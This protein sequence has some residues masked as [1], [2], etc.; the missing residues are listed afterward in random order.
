MAAKLAKPNAALT[1][2][3]ERS[4][5]SGGP[6]LP[7]VAFAI[8]AGVAGG[9][10][11]FY[12]AQSSDGVFA[13]LAAAYSRDRHFESRFSGASYGPLT[14]TRG[15]TAGVRSPEF[16]EAQARIARQL[17]TH[18]D[19][20]EWL[21]AKARA[22]LLEGRVDTAL[23]E[24]RHA[25]ES[26]GRSPEVLGDLAIAYLQRASQERNAPDIA[27]AIDLLGQALA[28]DPSNLVYRFNRALA[29]EQL[30]APHEAA[31]DWREFLA[32]EAPGGWKGEARDHLRH[33][34]DLL[35]R[36]R[37]ASDDSGSDPRPAA[38]LSA[39]LKQTRDVTAALGRTMIADHGDKW[40]RDMAGVSSRVAELLLRGDQSNARGESDDAGAAAAQAEHE[41]HGANAAAA[42]MAAYEQAYSLQRSSHPEQ[43]EETANRAIPVAARHGYVWFHA[44]LELTLAACRAMR[45]EFVAAEA[46][47]LDAER[48]AVAG[49]YAAIALQ[50]TAWH[51]ALFRY[52]GAYRDVLRVCNQTLQEYWHGTYPLARAY[53]CYFEMSGA[54]RD[55]GLPA[56]TA[57]FSREAVETA[58]LRPN[59]AIEGMIRS[60][61]A[62]DLA[63]AGRFAD[64]ERSLTEAERV[65]GAVKQMA[66]TNYYRA[67]ASLGWG[68]IAA[69]RNR[70]DE[71]LRRIEPLRT[72]LGS[73]QNPLVEIRYHRLRGDLLVERGA[74]IDAEGS[75]RQVLAA[76]AHSES[77]SVRASDRN[78]MTAEGQAALEA[79][80]E[81]LLRR[82]QDSAAIEAW[83]RNL[84]GFR[85]IP[86]V[87]SG[88]VRVT[89]AGLPNGLAVWA[90]GPGGASPPVRLALDPARLKILAGNLKR[91]VSDPHVSLDRI[92]RLGGELYGILL[93]PIVP[94]LDGA[95]TLLISLGAEVEDVP[96]EALVGP[97]G[98]W[99]AEKYQISYSLPSIFHSTAPHDSTVHA[100]LRSLAVASGSGARLFGREFPVLPQVV[101]ETR[102]VAQ[103][104]PNSTIL[105]STNWNAE[106]FDKELAQA[107]VFHFSGHAAVFP[108]DGALVLASGDHLTGLWASQI[109][110]RSLAACRL[111]VLAACST[112]RMD[113]ASGPGSV[114]ARAFLQAGVPRVVAARWDIDSGA[115]GVLM[116]TFYRDL[117]AGRSVEDALTAAAG[118]LRNDSRFAHPYYWAAFGL[119][120]N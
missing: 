46:A 97:D 107:E 68:R 116:S 14:T 113:D 17:Q 4:S 87:P 94:S 77:E 2:P 39:I 32:H 58:L 37:G 13:A 34:E 5:R 114:I 7:L 52:A 110:K 48:V 90:N 115:T 45:Q 83:E 42:I 10:W 117:G 104:F 12:R 89:F 85:S 41:E 62:E 23:E 106:V 27:V 44:Q 9:A 38:L 28:A 26:E 95:Q 8:L 49:H 35:Q 118:R 111:A 11:W 88:A 63:R 93:T 51:A 102:G 15:G 25:Q 79:M 18:P 96:F 66:S 75:F 47:T 86:H 70:P 101:E 80:V 57:S 21:R 99:L 81:L 120:R 60:I 22:D 54:A 30:P 119:F 73:F 20:P 82:H 33:L 50:G 16:L 6:W 55:L 31:D 24:L 43:C 108:G 69:L 36:Q 109:S 112:A 92:R 19:N 103:A 3:T 56:A 98:K 76:Y 74:A 29:R 72:A 100:R 84:P 61:H 1:V 40:V 65:L 105:T 64:A 67:Y 53:E 78:S 59:R 71:G 91:A